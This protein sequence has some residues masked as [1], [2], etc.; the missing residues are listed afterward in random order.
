MEEGADGISG[1]GPPPD[2]RPASPPPTLGR[3]LFRLEVLQ[4]LSL[5][6]SKVSSNVPAK[7]AGLPALQTLDVN[8]N[9]FAGAI[10]E[11]LFGRSAPYVTSC[12]PTTP[13]PSDG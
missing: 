12:S 10:S 5:A 3:G 13:S 7:L 8:A 9:A 11:G 2:P 6:H 4:S 1:Q